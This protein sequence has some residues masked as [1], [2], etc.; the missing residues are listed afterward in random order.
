MRPTAL[1]RIQPPLTRAPFFTCQLLSQTRK[2]STK[3]PSI[4][5]PL[6]PG[7]ILKSDSGQ[8]YRID[9]ILADRRKPLLCVYRASTARS[10]YII[11]N[12]I[13]GEFN[14]Q[15][16]LQKPLSA[17]PH[18]RAVIDTVR[19]QELFI[20]PFLTGDLL[21][22]SRKALSKPSR[23]EI[24]RGALCGL[25]DL[26]NRDILHND[27]KPNNVLLNYEEHH[28]GEIVINKVQIPDLEDTVIVPSGKW[29][30]GPLCGNAIWRSPE[31]WCRSRQNQASD[32][33]SFGIMMIYVMISE[34]VFRVSDDQLEAPDSWRYILRRHLSYFADEDGLNGF[35]GHIG[36]ENPF[37]ERLLALANTFTLEDPR[38]PFTRWQYVDPDLRDLVGK[39]TNLE[40]TR[41]ITAKEALRHCWFSQ[42]T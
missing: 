5:E 36:K 34:M 40:P 3:S 2:T 12:M 22:L 7:T 8:S 37:H 42:T 33:F 14:Y 10:N 32:V 27:I 1:I 20:Y 25:V 39:M 15:L 30:K 29:L 4:Q 21:R 17:R 11:K 24:L 13:P 18:V 38:Q 31:S 23:R 16:D 28:G 41:R 19:E 6:K 26:H 35:L 9:E